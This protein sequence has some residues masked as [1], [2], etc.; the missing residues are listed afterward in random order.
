M[1]LKRPV[2]RDNRDV[3]AAAASRD[4]SPSVARRSAA[5][6]DHGL[7]TLHGL[8]CQRHP[9]PLAPIGRLQGL[10]CRF[11]HIVA[12][13]SGD[14]R[15]LAPARAG[16]PP[17]AALPEAVAVRLR[18]D[19]VPL[20]WGEP[21]VV[22]NTREL[23]ARCAERGRSSVEIARA[24]PSLLTELQL[25]SWFDSVWWIR[26]V[27]RVTVATIRPPAWLAFRLAT[28]AAY[29]RGVRS[30]ATQ[31]DWTRWTKTSYTALV[32]HRLAGEG[33]PGQERVDLA[34]E[35]F[36]RQLR[37]L[38]RLGFRHLQPHE[39]LAIHDDPETA[40]PRRAFVATLDDGLLDC[41]APL[42]DTQERGI[43]LFISTAEAG[44]QAHWLD[45]EP[46]LG[47]DD[48]RALV[49]AEVVAGSHACHHRPLTQLE[50]DRLAAELEG[51]RLDLEQELGATPAFLAYPHGEYDTTV[52]GAAAKAGFRAAFTT[53]KGRNAPGTDRY[54]LRRVSIHAAD[55]VPAVLWKVATGEGLPSVWLQARRLL[56]TVRAPE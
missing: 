1:R 3:G 12:D 38:R 4:D 32:Y 45:D 8:A 35:K 18:R 43:Q 26:L 33:K 42:L 23:L 46:L 28:D 40:A 37:V 31:A 11:D 20:V 52:R 22:D 21:I 13:V 30:S 19:G 6:G 49:Q 44:G 36:A 34:P 39:L 55:G 29:W 25:G 24:D 10:I 5:R 14:E 2:L 48:V 50:P 9:R 27:R 7:V 16:L 15:L 53:A 56:K 47:W 54:C 51:S 41:L 17:G